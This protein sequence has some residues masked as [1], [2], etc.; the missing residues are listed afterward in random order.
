MGLTCNTHGTDEMY[1][2]IE[3]RKPEVETSFLEE[4]DS[5]VYNAVLKWT[6]D[7]A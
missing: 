3:V 1:I 6:P 2:Q 4:R 5:C 7:S